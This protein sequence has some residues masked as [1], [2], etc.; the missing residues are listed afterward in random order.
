[1]THLKSCVFETSDIDR[2]KLIFSAFFWNQSCFCVDKIADS[3]YEYVNDVLGDSCIL[4]W[5][6]QDH[7]FRELQ[8]AREK[9]RLR[10]GAYFIQC[11]GFVKNEKIYNKTSLRSYLRQF[12]YPPIPAPSRDRC[13]SVDYPPI[14]TSLLEH[15][16]HE[17]ELFRNALDSLFG[18]TGKKDYGTYCGQEVHVWF[19]CIPSQQ[20]TG[21][22]EGQCHI[23]ILAK[24]LDGDIPAWSD[25]FIRFGKDLLARFQTINL[26]VMI[27]P[28][29]LLYS[30]YFGE[31]PIGIRLNN[32][33]EKPKEYLVS[34]I[35]W[36]N[37]LCA[38]AEVHLPM[39]IPK[40]IAKTTIPGGAL[41]QIC[42]PLE[43]AEIPEYQRLK[44]Y[45]YPVL[46][47]SQ[48][49]HHC[50]YFFRG[51][52]EIVPVFKS[53][54]ITLGNKVLFQTNK[55]NTFTTVYDQTND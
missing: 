32:K 17:P 25:A 33:K 50:D 40:G 31:K 7:S 48:G 15:N 26:T 10:N 2:R 36:A 30:S 1:M 16:K 24:S 5:R 34:E 13:C 23:E 18:M 6:I 22:F 9:Y 49:I 55:N 29:A 45:L 14:Y 46:L 39:E 4:D 41:V 53:E 21:A 43:T 28:K 47:K 52:W 11:H 44:Q 37:L 27:N 8:E 54:I 42:E 51:H 35:G 12:M 19:D 38:E 20:K 3:L